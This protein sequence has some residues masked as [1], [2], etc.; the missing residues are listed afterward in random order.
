MPEPAAVVEP[1]PSG[2]TE[3]TEPQVS[4]QV[5][6]PTAKAT[7]DTAVEITVAIESPANSATAEGELTLDSGV[8]IDLDME[9]LFTQP[10]SVLS[11]WQNSPPNLPLPPPLIDL[12]PCLTPSS[13]D[14]VSLSAHHLWRG[15]AA[16]LPISSSV[17]VES[18]GSQTPPRSCDP[19][20]PPWLPAP[21]SPPE[22]VSP[23]A[24]SGSLVPPAP[25]W[26]VICLPPPR[27]C[28]PLTTPRPFVPLAPLSSSFPPAPPQSSVAPALPRPSGAPSTPRSTKPPA[29]TW[30]SASSASPWLFCSL[31]PPRAPP[32]PA[33]LSL[34]SPMES[35]ATPPQ[36][37]LPPSAPL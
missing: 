6:E 3:L 28:T 23:P 29:P 7:V 15:L 19:A 11:D 17:G 16:G 22:P 4:D 27:D 31:S 20:A 30:P 36:W 2:V 32:P 25:P 8:L 1:S 14:V 37:L 12:L 35:T 21:S 33:P 13:L 9:I 18:G 5:R 26:S 34:V 24:P 10:S